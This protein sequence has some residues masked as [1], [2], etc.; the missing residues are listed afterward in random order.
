VC[1]RGDTVIAKV[2]FSHFDS[3][4]TLELCKELAK[5]CVEPARYGPKVVPQTIVDISVLLCQ[6]SGFSTSEIFPECEQIEAI[7]NR[8]QVLRAKPPVGAKRTRKELD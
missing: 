1:R 3:I 5:L 4:L 8:L 2:L 6:A 7:N